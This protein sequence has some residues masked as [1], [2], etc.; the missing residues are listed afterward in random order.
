MC[1]GSANIRTRPWFLAPNSVFLLPHH[2]GGNSLK[3]RL[4]EQ[5]SSTTDPGHP[6][7]K[8][9]SEWIKG[10][11]K[12]DKL[13]NSHIP[14]CLPLRGQITPAA[15]VTKGSKKAVRSSKAYG[16][17]FRVKDTVIWI[18]APIPTHCET[19]A[20]IHVHGWR[21][22]KC[23]CENEWNKAKMSSNT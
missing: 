23:F 3:L 12:Q 21:M 15:K 7:T 6:V 16:M 20:S 14:V 5:V 18:P 2:I 1:L 22:E 17:G 9:D 4:G 13:G 11:I 8:L 19:S 10:I